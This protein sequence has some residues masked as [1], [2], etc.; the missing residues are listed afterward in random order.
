[1]ETDGGWKMVKWGERRNNQEVTNDE[2]SVTQKSKNWRKC[3]LKSVCVPLHHFATHHFNS[4]SPNKV[5]LLTSHLRL[6][7]SRKL[8][9][10]YNVEKQAARGSN[11]RK[12]VMHVY[13][14]YPC[15]YFLS[16][17]WLHTAGIYLSM[18]R[19]AGYSRD[20]LSVTISLCMLWTLYSPT[21]DTSS[22]C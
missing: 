8:Y 6:N 14:C 13:M 18:Q 16:L 1:M 2:R 3:L 11:P 12:C 17:S 10:S 22:V 21:Y 5:S 20:R 9:K 7:N 19:A 4:Y 15:N